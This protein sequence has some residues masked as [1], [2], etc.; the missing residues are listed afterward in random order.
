[1]LSLLSWQPLKRNRERLDPQVAAEILSETERTAWESAEGQALELGWRRDNRFDISDGDYLTMVMKKT[2]WLG[3]IHPCR[4]GV[5]IATGGKVHFKALVRFGFLFGAAFQI[6]DDLLNLAADDCYG[7][8]RDGDIWEGKRTLMLTHV[9]RVATPSNRLRMKTAFNWPR[10]RRRPEDVRWIREQMDK[11]GS[12]DYARTIASA[13]AAAALHEF[14]RIFCD[15][16]DGRDKAFIRALVPW[17][18][19]RSK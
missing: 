16:P 2:C 18:V 14:D 11:D 3:M 8:E 15:V 12:L 19:Q 7:K 17:V 10:E 5:L 1:M 4:V 9:Y 6:A 13:L